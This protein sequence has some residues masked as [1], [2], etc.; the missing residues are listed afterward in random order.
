M[1]QKWDQIDIKICFLLKKILCWLWNSGN[2]LGA[3]FI[4]A[5]WNWHCLVVWGTLN[6]RGK[7]DLWAP[8]PSE[9]RRQIVLSGLINHEVTSKMTAS[10]SFQK[11]NFC[12]L[13]KYVTL[14]YELT[15]MGREIGICLSSEE[16]LSFIFSGQAPLFPSSTQGTLWITHTLCLK[17]HALWYWLSRCQAVSRR[18]SLRS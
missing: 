5:L 8:G 10:S 18:A 14:Y 9:L 3:L 11:V 17:L 12:A 16:S 2:L 13:L 6:Q 1:L 4:V 7:F 15:D